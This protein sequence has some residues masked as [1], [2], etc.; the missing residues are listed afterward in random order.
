[1]DRV[2]CALEY[3]K[4]HFYDYKDVK[5][6]PREE[7]ARELDEMLIE[8]VDSEDSDGEIDKQKE[9]VESKKPRK[10]DIYDKENIEVDKEGEK[11]QRSDFRDHEHENQTVK[12]NK[13]NEI[14]DA[15]DLDSD[16]EEL[17]AP[18]IEDNESNHDKGDTEYAGP[19]E[20]YLKHID[21][22]LQMKTCTYMCVNQ[23]T[24]T[25]E[26]IAEAFAAVRGQ[27]TFVPPKTHF[28]EALANPVLF[29][30]KDGCFRQPR[31]IE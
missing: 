10:D 5:V 8:Q 15:S 28:V 23:E 12:H 17:I 3:F 2:Y 16:I 11:N 6:K 22:L 9:G 18:C 14:D 26:A 4:E 30:N 29:P 27:G 25:R 20:P 31:K 7:F 21:P 13:G 1:M 19:N 24:K